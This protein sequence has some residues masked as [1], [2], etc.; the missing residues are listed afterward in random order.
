MLR[1]QI[2]R[3]FCT[4]RDQMD[5]DLVIVGAGPAGLS[6]AIR[7]KQLSPDLNVCVVEKGSEVGSHILSGNIFEP[8]ALNELIPDWRAKNAPLRVPVTHDEF[9]VFPTKSIKVSI[10]HA[11]FPSELDN[12]GNYIIS[13]GDL[14]KW[15]ASEAETLGV[16]I[17]SGFAVDSPVFDTSNRVI[18]VR[19]KDT[20]IAK[21]KSHKPSYTP[22]IDLLGKQVIVAEGAR[23][24]IAQK[25]ISHYHLGRDSC[26]P[27]FSLGLKEVWEIDPSKHKQGSVYHGVGYPIHGL[28]TYGGSF[29]YHMDN[30]IVHLGVVIGLDYSSPYLN[31]YET[32]QDFKRH[33]WMSEMLSGGKSLS[34]GARVLNVGGYQA[35]PKLSFPGGLLVGCSAGL[36][37]LAK[38]KGT[39]TAMKSG[40][41]AAEL[42]TESI[43][44]NKSHVELTEFESTIK[45]SWIGEELYRVR[46][47]KPAF[48]LA[49]M[50]GGLAYGGA[51]LKYLKGREPWTFRWSSRDCDKTVLAKK[52]KLID[53]EKPDGKLT[54]DILENLARSG[55][56][57]EH[58]QPSHLRV[59]PDLIEVAKHESYEKLAGP[60][61]RFCPAKVYEFP[62]G[63]L[64]INAQNCIHCKCCSI[65][66][67]QEYIEWTVPEGGGGPQYSSM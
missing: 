1:R 39:H 26:P 51:F 45:S 27:T 53:Y 2:Q 29:V 4:A 43:T 60:E 19:T 8:R 46:N 20:G 21:N 36:L 34:Y 56:K 3:A 6:C 40:M 52:A 9:F 63:K 35:I 5:F 28:S 25:L 44:N 22:G 54:F 12:T 42:A 31:T 64:T 33:S 38:I 67:P 10:P 50:L 24:S 15:L 57:H 30:N 37:N 58:D 18:G 55:V 49:G 32:L 13:L 61:S 7:A 14:C 62:D 66:T 59:K 41:L 47:M 16:E 65:K 11:L 23:G 17:F 48:K